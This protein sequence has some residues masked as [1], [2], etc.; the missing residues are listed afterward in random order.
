M[1]LCCGT[2]IADVPHLWLE[3]IFTPFQV[4]KNKILPSTTLKCSY[5]LIAVIVYYV[6]VDLPCILNLQF[7]FVYFIILHMHRRLLFLA[8]HFVA[9]STEVITVHAITLQLNFY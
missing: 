9:C 5:L 1:T 7:I 6:Y 3:Q 4:N 2:D 8:N